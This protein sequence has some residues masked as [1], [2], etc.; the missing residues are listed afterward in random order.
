MGLWT[1][2]R[3]EFITT[4][5][6]ALGAAA[7]PAAARILPQSRNL[8]FL[9]VGDWGRDG[10][11]NQDKVANWMAHHAAAGGCDFIVSTG[12]NFYTF[13]VSS[14]DDT[15]WKT[16]YENVYSPELLRVPWF[17]VAGNHDWGGNIWAQLDRTGR[18]CWHMPWL[19]Y[20][21][22]GSRFGRPDVD[23][24]FIDTVVFSGD[25]GMYGLCGQSI[26][27]A[28]IAGQVEWLMSSLA[29]SR[30]AVKLVFGH[31]PIY[32]VGKHGGSKKLETLDKILTENGVSAYV[33][34]HDHCL[35]HI[36]SKQLDYICSGG[37]SQELLKFTGDPIQGGCVIKGDCANPKNPTWY[38]FIPGAGFAIFEAGPN[39]LSFEF[40]DRFGGRFGKIPIPIRD[41]FH[42]E[43]PGVSPI[44]PAGLK[45]R[46]YARAKTVLPCAQFPDP[47]V[48]L[49]SPLL[50]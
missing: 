34:G 3:R 36:R 47:L 8:R 32:S 5:P 44:D 17:P 11:Q 41:R 35:Y 16:S 1:P 15:K 21:I 22:C 28:D 39:D 24:F 38:N 23:L 43:R 40:V 42:A 9:V 30:A 49:I 25:E 18:G 14:V 29:R 31:H 2:T 13:G 46:A 48:K 27:P 50:D 37:G 7:I 6:L 19:F 20:N 12:D 33:C 4:A 45:D 10:T 26:R